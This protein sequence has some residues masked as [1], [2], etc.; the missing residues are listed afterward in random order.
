ML[1]Y[2]APAD[3][4]QDE[5]LHL[6]GNQCD[7]FWGRVPELGYRYLRVVTLN[8]GRTIHNAFPDRGFVP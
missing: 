7:Y 8:D 6:F 4:P 1:Q 5:A 2:A 3:A